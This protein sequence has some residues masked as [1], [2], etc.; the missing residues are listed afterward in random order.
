MI[1]LK[2]ENGELKMLIF[3]FSDLFFILAFIINQLKKL[4]MSKNVIADKSY[5]FALSIIKIYK[6]MVG[7]K[8]EFILS[9]QL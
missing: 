1:E 9:K 5:L 7:E 4:T 3:Y 6:L 8:K 2:S